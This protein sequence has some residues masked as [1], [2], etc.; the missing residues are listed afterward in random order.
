MSSRVIGNASVMS[1]HRICSDKVKGAVEAGT[2]PFFLLKSFD[3]DAPRF[4]VIMEVE[5][6]DGP[7]NGNGRFILDRF[8]KINKDRKGLPIRKLDGTML[9]GQTD[10]NF[11][12]EAYDT[13]ESA[14]I[15]AKLKYPEFPLFKWKFMET[16]SV[17]SIS[18]TDVDFLELIN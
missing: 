14:I 5:D 15:H 6:R 9:Y 16:T 7:A 17:A 4:F 1:S 11:I 13:L 10:I 3:T 8:H 18:V 2:N 12:P